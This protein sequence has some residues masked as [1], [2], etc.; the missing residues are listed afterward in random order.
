MGLRRKYLGD[1]GGRKEGR[2]DEEDS[3]EGRYEVRVEGV[4]GCIK[5]GKGYNTN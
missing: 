4:R 1:L 3:K 2:R 5:E